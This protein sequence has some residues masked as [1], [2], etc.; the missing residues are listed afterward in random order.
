L[1]H[2]LKQVQETS[3]LFVHQIFGCHDFFLV[4]KSR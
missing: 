1:E 3:L 4:V 2:F